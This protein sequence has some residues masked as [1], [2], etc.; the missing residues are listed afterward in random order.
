MSSSYIVWSADILAAAE[1]LQLVRIIFSF[2]NRN[3]PVTPAWPLAHPG[4]RTSSTRPKQL[5]RS[6]LLGDCSATQSS[7]NR[8]VSRQCIWIVIVRPTICKRV[9]VCVSERR[10]M[11]EPQVA[12]LVLIVAVSVQGKWKAHGNP[13]TCLESATDRN[14]ANHTDKRYIGRLWERERKRLRV[15][16]GRAVNN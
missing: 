6:L 9:R 4:L 14:T 5:L 11:R 13:S 3:A 12:H 10:C 16:R 15:D 7:A 2:F 8:F 1:K